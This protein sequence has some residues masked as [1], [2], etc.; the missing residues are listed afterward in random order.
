MDAAEVCFLFFYAKT[1]SS[2]LGVMCMI[3][4]KVTGQKQNKQKLPNLSALG[5]EYV[6][7]V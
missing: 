4:T 1:T 5:L 3:E 7:T 2:V 6:L